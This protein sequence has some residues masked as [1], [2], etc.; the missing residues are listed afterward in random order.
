MQKSEAHEKTYSSEI[1]EKIDPKWS[2]VKFDPT[3]TWKAWGQID[4]NFLFGFQSV[5]DLNIHFEWG[6]FWPH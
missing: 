1:L 6:Q 2:G 5:C 3:N 4:P